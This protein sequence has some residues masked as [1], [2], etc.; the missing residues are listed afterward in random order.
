MKE[1]EANLRNI[2]AAINAP[3]DLKKMMSLPG[4]KARSAATAILLA[5]FLLGRNQLRPFFL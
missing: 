3:P 2:V 5:H 4:R 1:K